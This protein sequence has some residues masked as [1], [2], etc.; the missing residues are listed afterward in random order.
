[1]S[2][3]QTVICMVRP[4]T[5]PSQSAK[6][7]RKEDRF[8]LLYFGH[9]KEVTSQETTLTWDNLSCSNFCLLRCPWVGWIKQPCRCRTNTYKNQFQ[10][11]PIRRHYSWSPCR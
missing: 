6:G 7:D 9:Q 10:D 8:V 2:K 1:M 4:E 3:S 11:C 5:L